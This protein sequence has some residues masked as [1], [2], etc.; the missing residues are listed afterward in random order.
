M[1]HRLLLLRR[2]LVKINRGPK[3]TGPL[4]AGFRY[5]S[6]ESASGL[7]FAGMSDHSMVI[8]LIGQASTQAPQPAHSSPL[9]FAFPS[10]TVIAPQGQASAQAPQPTHSS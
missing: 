2:P 7:S 10:S 9:T 5:S 3:K 8:R 6:G 4:R 1:R